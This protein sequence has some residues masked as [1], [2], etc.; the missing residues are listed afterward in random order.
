MPGNY[1]RMWALNGTACL[2][3]ETC[4]CDIN[5]TLYLD[6][7]VDHLT[8]P[9]RLARTV[10]GVRWTK[11]AFCDKLISLEVY[12]PMDLSG[13]RLRPIRSR[14]V[15][16][17][18]FLNK[19]SLRQRSAHPEWGLWRGKLTSPQLLLSVPREHNNILSQ[20]QYILIITN[21]PWYTLKRCKCCVIVILKEVTCYESK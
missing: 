19:D 15:P 7:L 5:N 11:E 3:V 17:L 6:G 21:K 9:G 1:R 20:K 18:W 16:S 14:Q 12:W 4:R 8:K 10:C 13:V 2:P